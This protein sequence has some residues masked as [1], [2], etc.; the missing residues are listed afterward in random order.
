MAKT[1]RRSAKATQLPSPGTEP[2]S[3][4]LPSIGDRTRAKDR[5][6][7]AAATSASS[8]EPQRSRGQSDSKRLEPRSTQKLAN[9]HD[10]DVAKI[11]E[12]YVDE[13]EATVPVKPARRGKVPD[14]P[15]APAAI[16]RRRQIV[17]TDEPK[18]RKRT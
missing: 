8:V 13:T 3:R 12:I 6:R 2:V 18:G 15:D 1:I 7:A 9:L 10:R 14:R 5:H 16:D 11:D 17:G 4:K